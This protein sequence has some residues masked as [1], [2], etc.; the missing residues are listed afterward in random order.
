MLGSLAELY[1]H[2]LFLNN[3]YEFLALEPHVA[4]PPSPQPVPEPVR[5]AIEF[6]NVS[7]RYPGTERL[8]LEGV[9]LT[10]EAGEVI[11]LVGENGAGKT[12][13]IK[14][15][16]RLYDPTDGCITLDGIDLRRFDPV[17]LRRHISVIF[18]DYIQ[19]QFPAWEN[20]GLGDVRDYANRDRITAAAQLA[21][22]HDVIVNLPHGYDTQ[23]GGMFE[24][25]QEL[26]QGQWQKVALARA[27]MRPA[28]IMVLDE[29]TSALD[30]MSEAEV[31]EQFRQL[32]A[33]RSAILISHRLSTVKMA[34]RI[35]V[36]DGRRIVE[37]GSHAELMSRG[38]LYAK[39]F[40]VQSQ[41]YK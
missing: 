19:Y 16:C 6:R 1:E 39:L 22:A 2:G 18:Q 37:V 28:A 4:A 14:L 9:D 10:I 36:L 41:Y 25:G 30:V 5:G 27:F 12:T 40:D 7:F 38:G 32:V 11:A 15:L 21:N 13:L 29:P 35:Y 23:L 31:F 26:S 33:G 8:V 20:I 3:F 34:H 24:G 17:D